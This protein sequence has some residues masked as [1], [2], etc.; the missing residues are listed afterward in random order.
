MMS[1]LDWASLADNL[2][3]ESAVLLIEAPESFD[4]MNQIYEAGNCLTDEA[5]RAQEELQ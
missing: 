5:K 1:S 3:R 4:L 2:V